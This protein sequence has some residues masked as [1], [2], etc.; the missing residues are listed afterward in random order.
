MAQYS[1][2]LGQ[3]VEVEYRAGDVLLTAKGKMAADTG[4]SIFLEEH[5]D[6]KGKTKTFRWEIP[7]PCILSV[8]Q[9]LA[10]A[11]ASEQR[12]AGESSKSE[13]S[14]VRAN[15]LKTRPHQI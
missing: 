7:Y 1:N 5:S 11:N 10:P 13:Q 6:Q 15:F 9:S 8:A 12:D 4:K 3:R 14:S 2:L